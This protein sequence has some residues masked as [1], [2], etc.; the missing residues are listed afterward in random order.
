[1]QAFYHKIQVKSELG[2]GP[3]ILDSFE[4]WKRLINKAFEI[5]AA[6]GCIRGVTK[7]LSFIYR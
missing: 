7:H 4:Q 1:V 2:P 3:M 6:C 5:L